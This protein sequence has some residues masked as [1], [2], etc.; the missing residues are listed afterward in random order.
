MKAL[1]MF[2][3]DNT[4]PL[5]PLL[6]REVRHVWCAVYDDRTRIWVEYNTGAFGHDIRVACDGDFDIIKWYESQGNEV[7]VIETDGPA[8]VQLPFIMNNCVGLVKAVLGLSSWA[9]TPRQLRK[10][11]LTLPKGD[12]LCESFALT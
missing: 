5:A 7:F 10:H 8:K 9:L 11:I 1:V 2:S 6:S 3:S 12:P 4:H